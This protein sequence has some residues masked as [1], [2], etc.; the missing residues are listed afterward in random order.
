VD[1]Y[2]ESS[3]IELY[4]EAW[5][6]DTSPDANEFHTTI[7]PRDITLSQFLWEDDIS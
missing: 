7:T 6:D 1:T 2:I 4:E 3:S 5:I